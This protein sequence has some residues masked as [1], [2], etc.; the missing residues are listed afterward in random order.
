[1]IEDYNESI[2]LFNLYILSA[3]SLNPESYKG[4][5]LIYAKLNLTEKSDYYFNLYDKN[6]GL[7]NYNSIIINN[8]YSLYDLSKKHNFNLVLMQ[9]PTRSI[10]SLK[11]LF[12]FEK[13]IIYISNEDNFK[14]ELLLYPYDFIF[15]DNFASDFGHCTEYGNQLIANNVYSSL[16][17]YGL[18]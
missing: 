16:D 18:I 3:E 11:D 6:K 7:S 4:L 10:D 8:Y 15:T 12:I 1:M 5:G 13:D 14:Q 9:Y 17:K 2:N